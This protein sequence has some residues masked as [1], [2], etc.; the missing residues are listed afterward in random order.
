MDQRI[1]ISISIICLC[2]VF[3]A[4]IA[5]IM[6]FFIFKKQEIQVNTPLPAGTGIID[7]NLEKRDPQLARL[8]AQQYD[9]LYGVPQ[10]NVSEDVPLPE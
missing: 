8:F 2:L 3:S 10:S 1:I 7:E 5:I 6:Y 4:I 9:R